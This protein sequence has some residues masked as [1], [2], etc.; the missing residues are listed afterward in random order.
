V[1]YL[2]I[3]LAAAL[4]LALCTVRDLRTVHSR[5]RLVPLL[6]LSAALLGPFTAR[7]VLR[8]SLVLEML[9]ARAQ[10]PRPSLVNPA[11]LG[12]MPVYGASQCVGPIITGVCQGSV[13]GPPAARCYGTMLNGQ[14]TGPM[15]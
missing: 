6:L 2:P 1:R 8:V 3:A 9:A 4:A 5:S 7:L 15:F 11:P 13:I 14:C 10:Q 12:G